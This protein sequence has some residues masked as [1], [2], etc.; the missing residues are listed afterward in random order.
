MKQYMK[1]GVGRSDGGNREVAGSD[2][3]VDDGYL[4]A[5]LAANGQVALVIGR[6]NGDSVSLLNDTPAFV[7][8]VPFQEV[9]TALSA[10][11]PQGL[12]GYFEHLSVQFAHDDEVDAPLDEIVDLGVG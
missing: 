1:I 10:V 11:L 6:S 8:T 4:T 3:L 7:Q 2:I 12:F 5:L 9:E